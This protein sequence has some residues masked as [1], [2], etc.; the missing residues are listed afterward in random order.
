MLRIDSIEKSEKERDRPSIPVL[1]CDP[2]EVLEGKHRKEK[3]KQRNIER[4]RKK[5]SKKEREL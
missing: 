4:E 3:K 5:E 1:T 2:F